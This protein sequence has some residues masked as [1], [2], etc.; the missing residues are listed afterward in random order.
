MLTDRAPFDYRYLSRRL[1]TDLFQHEQAAHP[2]RRASA[3]IDL[4]F[5]VNLQ[6][7]RSET[8]MNNLHA[9]AKKSAQLVS[10]NTGDLSTPGTY[11]RDELELHTVCSHPTWVGMAARSRA[12]G[13]RPPQARTNRCSSRSSDR[14]PT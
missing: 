2:E 13:A 3:S 1:L 8:D 12:T 4:P 6:L 10:D 14:H 9:L 5:G 11:V 7:P